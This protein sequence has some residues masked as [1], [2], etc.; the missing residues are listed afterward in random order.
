MR[1]SSILNDL[2]HV[3]NKTECV[4]VF[5]CWKTCYHIAFAC[6]V[7][8]LNRRLHGWKPEGHHKCPRN[9]NST[10][11]IRTRVPHLGNTDNQIDIIG[12][13]Q[14]VSTYRLN[15]GICILKSTY[16]TMLCCGM[17]FCHWFNLTTAIR[18]TSRTSLFMQPHR[19][20]YSVAFVDIINHRFPS[21]A[22]RTQGI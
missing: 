10:R 19:S 12:Y 13:D 1:N 8:S 6:L 2:E 18:R 21:H 16:F 15:I 7:L 14:F 9:R 22:Y 20:R 4:H 5:L 3:A 17:W 11:W